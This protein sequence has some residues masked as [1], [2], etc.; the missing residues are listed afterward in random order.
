MKGLFPGYT[1]KTENHR[2]LWDTALFVFDTNVLLNA[3]RYKQA[4]RDALLST[5]RALGNRAWIPYHVAL[6]YHRGRLKVIADQNNQFSRVQQSLQEAVQQIHSITDGLDARH[7]SI[8]CR[9]FNNEIDEATEKF[10]AILSEKSRS[11]QGLHDT[12]PTLTE[13][14]AIFEAK[15]GEEPTADKLAKLNKDAESRQSKSIPPGY[16]DANKKDAGFQHNDKWYVSS[17]GDYYLWSQTLEHCSNNSIRCLIVVT[18]DMKDDWIHRVSGQTIGPRPEL[19]EEAKRHGVNSLQLYNSTTFVGYAKDYL[20]SSEITK[21][22]L[23][24]IG[25]INEIE[26]NPETAQPWSRSV[27]CKLRSRAMRFLENMGYKVS[28]KG[29]SGWFKAYI[30]NTEASVWTIER[31]GMLEMMSALNVIIA[32]SIKDMGDSDPTS[33][34]FIF[35]ATSKNMYSQLVK[36]HPNF[37][38]AVRLAEQSSV[39]VA[40]VDHSLHTIDDPVE[41]LNLSVP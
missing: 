35:A 40:F 14:E 36:S 11:Q 17:Y 25:Q 16:K 18:D 27:K 10:I 13:I 1:Y 23:D 30:D 38:D 8:D 29:Q 34:T 12:D 28:Y 3:Y 26:E 22:I 19:I 41:V 21:D 31:M 33:P 5:I 9:E 24:E 2:E 37:M 32:Y 4:A 20:H 7:S 39:F 6:E 15:V